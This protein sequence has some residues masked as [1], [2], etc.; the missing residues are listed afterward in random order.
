MGSTWNRFISTR[1]DRGRQHPDVDRPLFKAWQIVTRNLSNP[2]LGCARG[3]GPR[4]QQRRVRHPVADVL[5]TREDDVIRLV[6]SA[7]D[8][9]V[10][11]E[12]ALRAMLS[13]TIMDAYPQP[14][15]ARSVPFRGEGA[16]PA[17]LLLDMV[18]DLEA[19]LEI[20]GHGADVTVDGVLRN[21][22]GAY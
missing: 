4:A 17:E 14:E 16:N 10:A 18:A 6:V 15:P 9:R 22:E 12:E 7:S 13:V 3:L 11:L 5:L 21:T 2:R 20:H 8:V 19:Q 1:V